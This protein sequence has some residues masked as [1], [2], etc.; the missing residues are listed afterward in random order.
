VGRGCRC[1]FA[2]G[3]YWWDH[4]RIVNLTFFPRANWLR[5]DAICA[6]N[7]YDAEEVSRV[8]GGSQTSI[9]RERYLK[10]KVAR[11]SLPSIFDLVLTENVCAFDISSPKLSP[12]SV[13][14]YKI[15]G[16]D[17][18]SRHP[19]NEGFFRTLVNF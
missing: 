1:L 8:N 6:E 11:G 7:I 2:F 19:V 4:V 10:V 9:P 12:K 16:Y 18:Y 15:C 14:G 17:E 5:N 13:N 3:T